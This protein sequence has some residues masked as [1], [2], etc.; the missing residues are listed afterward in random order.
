ML[1]SLEDY[2]LH[3]TYHHFKN[4]AQ[5]FV[6]EIF[7][8]LVRFS[9]LPFKLCSI[10]ASHSCATAYVTC[11]IRFHNMVR[12][13]T[14]IAPFYLRLH[15]MDFVTKIIRK[16]KQSKALK[17]CGYD[18][19]SCFFIQVSKHPWTT[20]LLHVAKGHGMAMNSVP[21]CLWLI[22][23]WGQIIAR[24]TNERLS[25]AFADSSHTQWYIRFYD[26]ILHVWVSESCMELEIFFIKK[27]FGFR[28][29]LWNLNWYNH[30]KKF[31][32]LP[33]VG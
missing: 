25:N 33:C 23:F 29:N 12:Y 24:G 30:P 32:A 18:L 15:N 10:T 16:I 13:C 6:I 2:L 5:L 27:D 17:S 7:L 14:A 11:L 19:T 20:W 31:E 26:L 3:T 9:C 8:L 21:G 4:Q 22:Y 1:F 28:S